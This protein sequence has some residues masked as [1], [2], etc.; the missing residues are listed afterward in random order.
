MNKKRLP[1]TKLN[2]TTKDLI[3]KGEW[4][5]YSKTLDSKC[6]YSYEY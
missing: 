6:T 2:A 4:F 3:N 5:L 1:S